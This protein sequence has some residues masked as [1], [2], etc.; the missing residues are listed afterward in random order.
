MAEETG[1]QVTDT[2]VEEQAAVESVATETVETQEEVVVEQSEAVEATT[3]SS[4]VTSFSKDDIEWDESLGFTDETKEELVSKY[5]SWF[6]D[7]E[8]ANAYLKE[9][10]NANKINKENQAKKIA[11]LEAGWEKSLKTDA[12]FGKDYE[13]NK[14]KVV[15]LLSKY[16][17]ESELAELNKYGFTKSPVLNKTLLKIAREFSDAK[18]VGAGQ[19]T[20]TVSK[21][22]VDRFG[23]TM[24]DFTKKQ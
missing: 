4:A 5:S 6:K 19:P 12:D 11:E 7:K 17:S 14:K 8:S 10:A 23:N 18:V 21:Q 3:E 20:T 1:T 22:P 9:L 16:T 24:F 13:G 15:D 2:V